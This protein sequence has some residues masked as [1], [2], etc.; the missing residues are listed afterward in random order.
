MQKCF[1]N[2]LQFITIAT[3]IVSLNSCTK[4]ITIP[5]KDVDK[6]LVIEAQIGN[7]AKECF[8]QLSKTIN[9]TQSNSIAAVSGAVVTISDN[10]G[11]S[12][13]LKENNGDGFYKNDTAIGTPGNIYTLNVIAEGKTYSSICAMPNPVAIDSIYN[14]TQN[15]FNQ[16]IKVVTAIAKDDA[17]YRNYYRIFVVVNGKRS[18]ESQITNDD[19]I[20]GVAAPINFPSVGPNSGDSS[21]FNTGN[22]FGVMLQNVDKA[23]YLYFNSKSQNTNGQSGA[24]AN[25]E[26]NIIGGALGYFNA[27][28]SAYKETIMK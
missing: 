4:T 18:G 26:T 23:M 22:I 2:T 8:V 3:A 9:Y 12:F 7:H 13:L 1:K 10:V 5:I 16:N 20:N 28:T 25:P 15:V 6:K 24:P 17:N 27:H 19:F 11:N 14:E 21:N